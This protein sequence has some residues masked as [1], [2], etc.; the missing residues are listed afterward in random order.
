MNENW[1]CKNCR[2]ENGSARNTCWKC[3][4]ERTEV[5]HDAVQ[6]IDRRKFE[7]KKR[8]LEEAFAKTPAGKARAAKAA[9][10]KIF[11]IDI[12]LSKTEAYTVAMI[13]AFS[14]SANIQDYAGT[15]QAIED[16]GWRLDHVGYVYRITGSQ[17]RDKFLASG[18][19]EAVSGEIVG[20][21]I[22]RAV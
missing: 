11:Q 15:I 3:K 16:E 6:E 20:I 9:G 5:E 12:P 8:K 2:V 22:F 17:S 18:Q 7:E 21:Y 1:I 10:M 19:Q 14:K 13:G 4:R